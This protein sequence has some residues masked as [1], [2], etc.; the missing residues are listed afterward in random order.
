MESTKNKKGINNDKNNNKKRTKEREK[1]TAQR[2]RVVCVCVCVCVGGGGGVGE[3]RREATCEKHNKRLGVQIALSVRHRAKAR[4]GGWR[5]GAPKINSKRN[6]VK[7]Y[8][9]GTERELRAFPGTN[10]PWNLGK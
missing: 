4:Q 6:Y 3:G 1:G 10:N 8:G 2:E 9:P 7:I 5:S